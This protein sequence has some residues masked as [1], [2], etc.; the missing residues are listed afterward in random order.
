MGTRKTTDLSIT[1][2]NELG[3]LSKLTT[4]LT[5][6]NINV[7]SLVCWE[8]GKTANFRLVTSDNG[9]A[10]E[11]WTK[12]GY[13]VNETPV[14]LW[15]TTNTPGKLNTATT[16]LA[17]SDINTICVYA[18]TTGAGETTVAFYTNNPDRTYEILNKI[19]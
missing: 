6:S 8:E 2:T 12:A 19:G 17:E 14:V 3:V 7:E 10:K 5:S 16:A 15:N 9:K 13:T 18:S 11:I 4:P 1:T